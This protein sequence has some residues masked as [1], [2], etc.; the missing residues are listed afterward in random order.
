[1]LVYI[2]TLYGSDANF[3]NALSYSEEK[4]LVRVSNDPA[5]ICR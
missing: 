1:M 4:A 2:S 5:T 3:T